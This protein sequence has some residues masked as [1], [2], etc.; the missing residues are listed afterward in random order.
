MKKPK[1]AARSTMPPAPRSARQQALRRLR[2][3][4][5]IVGGIIACLALVVVWNEFGNRFLP[6]RL[7]HGSEEIDDDADDPAE[8]KINPRTPPGPA[9]EGMVWVPG[10]EFWMGGPRELRD[11]QDPAV[12]R[13]CNLGMECFPIHKVTVSGFWMDQFEVTNE[14]FAHF[15]DATGYVTVAEKPVS[16]REAPDALPEERRP[17]SLVFRPPGPNE[18]YDLAKH[19]WW[20][21]ASLCYGACWKQP[22]GPGSTIRGREN[23]PVVH[24]CWYDAAAYCKWAGKRLPTEAEWEFAARGGLDRRKYPWGDELKP[25]GKCMANFWQGKFPVEN[26]KEDG[27]ERTAPAGSYP[28]NGYGLHDM[29]GNV[30]EWCADYYSEDYYLESPRLNPPGPF[31]EFNRA[32]LLKDNIA[33][34]H[35]VERVQRGGSFL[36]AENYCQRYIVGSRGKGEVH[37]SAN[38]IGFRGAMSAK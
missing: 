14:Q 29:A 10:G 30:W 35:A 4:G 21:K 26:T 32:A 12:C 16:E 2:W 9:P 19:D 5:L 8:P 15:V 33:E 3:A 24:I 27:Y 20:N 34:R 25:G 28:P 18:S 1:K 7:A 11:C 13:L 36:C 37:S 31:A 6:M 17:C 38:H 22:E 23:H